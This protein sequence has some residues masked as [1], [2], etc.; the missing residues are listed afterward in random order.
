MN[1][2]FEYS[3]LLTIKNNSPIGENMDYKHQQLLKTSQSLLMVAHRIVVADVCK[4]QGKFIPFGIGIT[5]EGKYLTVALEK[6]TKFPDG[7]KILIGEDNAKFG[8]DNIGFE[9]AIGYIILLLQNEAHEERLTSAVICFPDLVESTTSVKNINMIL[10]NSNRTSVYC[11][12]TYHQL[13]KK[14]G[15]EF[16]DLGGKAANPV[17][18]TKPK[19]DFKSLLI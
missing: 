1:Q 2:G 13:T 10:E 7:Q 4:R 12:G 8:L 19:Q 3:Q 5:Q 15:W 16:S 18:F 17:V 9:K 14:S 6:N 11:F